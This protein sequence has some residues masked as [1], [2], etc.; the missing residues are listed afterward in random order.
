MNNKFKIIV[1]LY[2]WKDELKIPNF[3]FGIDN[4]TEYV[5]YVL[6]NREAKLPMLFLN[7][8]ALEEE[9]VLATIGYLFHELGHIKHKTYIGKFTTKFKIRSE[10]LAEAFAIKQITKY[11]PEYKELYIKSWKLT[12]M[13]KEWQ[14]EYKIHYRAFSQIK[15]Y[16]E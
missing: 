15:E 8:K 4:K 13:N 7:F 12:M 3:L 11:F 16:K 1:E 10:F 14:K 2:H 6:Y 5:A 9:P